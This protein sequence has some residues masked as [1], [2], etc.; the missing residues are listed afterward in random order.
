MSPPKLR[1][2][3]YFSQRLEL[4]VPVELLYQ[5]HAR[6][7]AFQRLTPPWEPVRVVASS[8]DGIDA[9]KW[10][11]M[12]LDPL[13]MEWLA[14]HRASLENRFFVDLQARGPFAY[15]QHQ[16]LFESLGAEQ[17]A[18]IDQVEYRLPWRPLSQW[19]EA[20]VHQRLVRMFA[21][22]HR[23][24]QQDI[25]TH[26]SYQKV[27]AQTMNILISGASGLVGT[28]LTAFLKTGGHQVYTL[29]RHRPRQQDEIQW[30]V[31]GQALNPEDLEPLQLDAVIH[32]AGESIMG[33][34]TSEKKER[35]LESRVQGT[36]L[37]VDTLRKLEH[38]P[39]VLIC[40]SAVGFYGDR[41][42]KALS[43]QASAGSDFLAQVCQAWE[44]EACKAEAFMRVVR[45]RTGIVLSARG[46]AL[47]QMLLPFQW[48]VGGPLGSGQQFMSWIT[49]DDMLRAFYH[50]LYTQTLS[51]PVNFTAPTPVRNQRFTT[52]LA[53]TLHRPA[54]FQ[55]PAL[56]LQWT[57]GEMAEALLLTSTRAVPEQ[58]ISSGFVFQYPD[59]QQGLRHVLGR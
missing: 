6:P 30:D 53:E 46:G 39:Q 44:A 15:W 9:H 58:L 12:R 42:D 1:G 14:R 54:F 45:A 48:G 21:Y 16:H 19:A 43:E 50:C 57:L 2:M 40:A 11:K 18:L 35:I 22:R 8:G 56:A 20:Q 38:K 49:L 51:G 34:W 28:A 10:M 7:G 13:P 4:N 27:N 24:T 59:L 29:V 31:K 5:W 23:V 55:V 33:R 41:K 26:H 36:R 25:L 52:C 47:A 37:L 32:L 3:S 17:S